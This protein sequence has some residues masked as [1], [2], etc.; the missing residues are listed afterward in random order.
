MLASFM[1]SVA[2]TGGIIGVYLM[3][4]LVPLTMYLILQRTDN[5]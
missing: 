2:I 4:S 3:V 1:T 5:A